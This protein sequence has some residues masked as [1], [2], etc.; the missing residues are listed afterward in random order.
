[1]YQ[2]CP[3]LQ[4]IEGRIDVYEQYGQNTT[5]VLPI[6]RTVGVFGAVTVVWQA[7]PGEATL[8][9]YA[10]ESGTVN[11]ANTQREGKIYVTILDDND[12]EPMEVGC[13]G[14]TMLQYY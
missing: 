14:L 12:Y 9:D 1:M 6:A 7:D 11:L 8:M 3:I 10:P 5:I 13:S 2:N 4:N